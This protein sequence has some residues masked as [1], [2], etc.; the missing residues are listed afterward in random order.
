MVSLV[1]GTS[2]YVCREDFLLETDLAHPIKGPPGLVSLWQGDQM[3][4]AYYIGYF[5]PKHSVFRYLECISKCYHYYKSRFAE[6][7]LL[8][9]FHG[10]STGF[11]KVLLADVLRITQPSH[12]IEYYKNEVTHPEVLKE[13][14]SLLEGFFY[15]VTPKVTVSKS[16]DKNKGDLKFERANNLETY[17]GKVGRSIA[18]T[19]T[20]LVPYSR[21]YTQLKIVLNGEPMSEELYQ[22][23]L[24]KICGLCKVTGECLGIGIIRDI[25]FET[26][27]IYVL[28][29]VE[30]LSEAEVV[31]VVSGEG[32]LEICKHS[33]WDEFFFGK[34]ETEPQGML[35]LT[36]MT[37]T[38]QKR[39]PPKKS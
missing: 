32:C 34:F 5:S 3:V 9:H 8:V 10:W 39:H 20:K 21:F 24:G 16:K 7:T 25:N 33:L 11:G 22:G 37:D 2:E 6:K 14:S 28:A 19:Y 30:D 12:I 1:F 4:L 31:Q 36:T 17:F 38:L 13:T 35:F 18:D 27:L 15:S 29:K 23:L 26:G